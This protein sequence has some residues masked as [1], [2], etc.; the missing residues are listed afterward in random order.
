MRGA[1]RVAQSSENRPISPLLRATFFAEV[2]ARL[3]GIDDE[4]KI[5]IDLNALEDDPEVL[6]KLYECASLM[7]QSSNRQE[8]QVGYQMLEVVDKMMNGPDSKPSSIE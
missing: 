6:G 2:S 4:R 8:S 3:T 1:G 5:V 7:I